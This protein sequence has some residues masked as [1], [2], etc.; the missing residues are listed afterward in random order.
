MNSPQEENADDHFWTELLS[1]GG[2][3]TLIYLLESRFRGFGERTLISGGA[4]VAALA[5]LSKTKNKRSRALIRG[6]AIASGISTS[7]VML[8]FYRW[9]QE[10]QQAIDSL[11]G[12]GAADAE[13]A[14]RFPALNQEN[15]AS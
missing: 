3:L 7:A 10:R 13:E 6:I 12:A 14:E 5:G 8:D 9:R 1:A 11:N 4:F 15:R 2:T